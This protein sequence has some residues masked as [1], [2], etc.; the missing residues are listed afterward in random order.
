MKE[1]FV[2]IVG[3]EGLYSVSN[4]GMIY[5]HK[6]Y[7]HCGKFLKQHKRKDGYLEVGLYK[8]K[9]RKTF[10]VH[11][12]V[13]EAFV[14]NASGKPEINHKDGDKSNNMHTN[15]EWVTSSENQVHAIKNGLQTFSEKHRAVA[16]E[17]C[18]K[19]GKKNKGKPNLKLR[20]LT[21]GDALSIRRLHVDGVSMRKLAEKFNVDKGT[22]S[23]IVKGER[24]V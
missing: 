21:M 12:L 2:D 15:L 5:S 17:T 11:R 1:I 14:V 10:S 18:R 13:G 16:A 6:K 20:K 8:N 23:S 4:L 24:Y 22:I 9:K 19:N 7:K 3:Y